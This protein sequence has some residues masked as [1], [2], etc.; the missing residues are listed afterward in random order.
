MKIY[1]SPFVVLVSEYKP[2][3]GK[4]KVDVAAPLNLPFVLHL[5]PERPPNYPYSKMDSD[6]AVREYLLRLGGKWP[7]VS[8]VRHMMAQCYLY[9]PI[10]G[11]L[12]AAYQLLRSSDN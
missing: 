4:W 3:Q 1:D 10:D 12:E 8:L 2:D 5:Y 7:A 11:A 9:V 6:A